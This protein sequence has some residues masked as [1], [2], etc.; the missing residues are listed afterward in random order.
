MINFGKKELYKQTPKHKLKTGTKPETEANKQKQ[1]TR[2]IPLK[3][4]TF[5]QRLL[6]EGH[7]QNPGL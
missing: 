4:L 2:P 3:S 1:S 5:E 6:D 7:C